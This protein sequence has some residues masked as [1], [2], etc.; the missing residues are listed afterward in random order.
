MQFLF[1]YENSNF[2]IVLLIFVITHLFL[3]QFHAY[4]CVGVW[5]CVIA[6]GGQKSSD[7][8]ELKPRAIMSSLT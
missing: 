3:F 2:S 4:M 6:H 7:P 8:L 5:V 1:K